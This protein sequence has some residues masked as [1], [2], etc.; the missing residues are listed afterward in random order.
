MSE[1]PTRRSDWHLDKNISVGHIVSTMM[2]ALSV[3]AW[4][5]SIEKRV[6]KNEQSIGHIIENTNRIEKGIQ[7][8]KDN[9]RQDYREIS[10][11]LDDIKK[12]MV[13]IIKESRVNVALKG[14]K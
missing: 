12:D 11:K 7:T 9:Q 3:F 6:D 13:M 5:T 10:A 8:I 14:D 2:I 1:E 4:A